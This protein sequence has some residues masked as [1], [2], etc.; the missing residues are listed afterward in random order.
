MYAVNS[1]N[2]AFAPAYVQLALVMARVG[3]LQGALVMAQRA[4]AL[5]PHRA[6]YHL[7]VARVQIA[8]NY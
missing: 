1:A 2:N 5:E 7:L 8:S 6:G 4:E 3:D